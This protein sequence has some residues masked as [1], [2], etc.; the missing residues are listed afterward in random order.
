MSSN[1]AAYRLALQKNKSRLPVDRASRL[2]HITEEMTHYKKRL[3]DL[4]PIEQTRVIDRLIALRAEQTALCLEEL[5]ESSPFLVENKTKTIIAAFYADC[6][7]L[8]AAT[9]NSTNG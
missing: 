3:L 2:A 5:H 6:A 4:P 9:N 8:M 7:K 1:D